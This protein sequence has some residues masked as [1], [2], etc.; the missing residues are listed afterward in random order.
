MC[1]KKLPEGEQWSSGTIQQVKET[2]GQP[3]PSKRGARVPIGMRFDDI[4][5]EV[6]VQPVR[7]VPEPIARRPVITQVELAKTLKEP[8]SLTSYGDLDLN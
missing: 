2:L 3:D 6:E 4:P 1:N 8:R 5:V 7:E